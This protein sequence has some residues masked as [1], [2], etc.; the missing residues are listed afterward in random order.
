ME[1]KELKLARK[2]TIELPIPPVQEGIILLRG[3]NGSGKTTLL[4]LL[5]SK[6]NYSV[7]EFFPEK[8]DLFLNEGTVFLEETTVSHAETLKKNTQCINAYL[9]TDHHLQQD[10]F[11]RLNLTDRVLQGKFKR[12]S[13]GE[14]KKFLSVMNLSQVNKS[15]YYLDEPFE[16]VDAK[17]KVQL[18]DILR[19][20]FIGS[21][22]TLYL[23]THNTEIIESIP[24]LD[25]N[26]EST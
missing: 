21:G 19:T 18:L 13:T 8:A 26:I 2:F 23:T 20:Q 24:Y 9:N 5:S 12:C 1:R 7:R 25:F 11:K 6:F 4:R 22:K 15:I 17:S 3:S 16:N 14:K 10:Y